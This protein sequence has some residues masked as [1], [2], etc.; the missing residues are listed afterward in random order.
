MLV[1][2]IV[3][4]LIQ[5]LISSI[6]TLHVLVSGWD[7]FVANVLRFE[8]QIHQVLRDLGFMVPDILHIW[9]SWMELKDMAK[10]WGCPPSHLLRDKEVTT[11]FAGVACL[12]LVATFALPST[13]H[14]IAGF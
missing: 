14:T 10:K 1:F 12:W 6:A 11:A 5:Y 4:G 3:I 7:Q 9:L 8:G 13:D 2:F